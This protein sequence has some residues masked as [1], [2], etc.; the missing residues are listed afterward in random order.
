MPMSNPIARLLHMYSDQVFLVLEVDA[1]TFDA[2]DRKYVSSENP[3]A[4]TLVLLG[5]EAERLYLAEL[6]G[7]QDLPDYDYYRLVRK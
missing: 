1:E 2:I 6:F 7:R 3:E 5:N 4:G